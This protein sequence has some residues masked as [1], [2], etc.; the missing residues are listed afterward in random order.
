MRTVVISD[1]HLGSRG[2]PRPAAASGAARPALAALPGADEVVVLGD[3][4]ELREVPLEEGLAVARP[5]LED[6]GEA[7][8]G[9]RVVLVPGNHDHPLAQPVLSAGGRS[10]LG[11]ERAAPPPRGPVERVA[12]RLGRTTLELA[13]PGV[14]IRA[15]V[16]ATHGHYLDL[17]NAVPTLEMLAVALSARL[18]GDRPAP[19]PAPP[20]TKPPYVA[21]TRRSSV[22]GGPRR[23]RV[24]RRAPASPC[25]RGGR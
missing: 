25:A 14:W 3:A 11:L 24:R 7:L 4:L 16:Y 5:F 21:P 10:G 2:A 9:G 15:G 17:H 22:S 19:A 13:Y 12:S 20:T 18:D 8:G 23:P 1:L 6:V